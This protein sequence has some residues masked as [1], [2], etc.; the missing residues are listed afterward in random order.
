MFKSDVALVAGPH[1]V[2]MCQKHAKNTPKARCAQ[3]TEPLF[4][5]IVAHAVHRLSGHHEPEG[6]APVRKT[7]C[8]TR[9]EVARSCMTEAPKSPLKARA[10][11]EN[12]LDDVFLSILVDACKGA[13]TATTLRAEIGTLGQLHLARRRSTIR[14]RDS[15]RRFTPQFCRASKQCILMARNT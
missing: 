3:L 6:Q 7:Q 8:V 9:S 13:T 15:R 14:A 1:R 2:H 10:S 4:A 5:N 11:A 12:T